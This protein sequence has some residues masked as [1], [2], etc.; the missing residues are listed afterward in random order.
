MTARAADA[1]ARAVARAR[2]A[3]DA[4]AA[5]LAAPAAVRAAIDARVTAAVARAA[6]AVAGNYARALAAL[7]EA[8]DYCPECATPRDSCGPRAPTARRLA[9]DTGHY[10][11][12]APRPG[13][14]KKQ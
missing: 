5:Y 10:H 3:L 2:A 12:G 9:H 14:R 13:R 6:A 7:N 1:A 11:G 4:R 8:G